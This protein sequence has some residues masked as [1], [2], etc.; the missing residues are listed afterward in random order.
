MAIIAVYVPRQMDTVFPSHLLL[1]H[2]RLWRNTIRK[3]ACGAAWGR[4]PA[5][6]PASA[7][8]VAAAAFRYQPPLTTLLPSIYTEW[9]AAA[10]MIIGT[11]MARGT[12]RRM[13]GQRSTRRRGASSAPLTI[14]PLLMPMAQGAARLRSGSPDQTLHGW[15]RRLQHRGPWPVIP[16]RPPLPQ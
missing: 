9:C 16:P 3:V 14:T 4:G 15:R 2:R 12:W 6:P 10:V 7:T 11:G 8:A 1:I 5:A 13:E